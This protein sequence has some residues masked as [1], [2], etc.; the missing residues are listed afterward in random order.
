MPKSFSVINLGCAKNEVDGEG[1]RQVL[2]AAGHT[3]ALSPAHA[4]VVVVN[5][6]GFI[7]AATDESLAELRRLAASKRPG[8]M[9]VAAG[10]L[11]ERLGAQ[12]AQEVPQVDAVLGTLRWGEIARLLEAAA[13]SG[14]RPAWIG[15]GTPEPCVPRQAHGG[16]AYLKIADGCSAACAFCTIPAIKG[17]YRSRPEEDIV[18]EAAALAAQGVRELVLIAQDSTY[19]GRDRGERGALVRLL[20]R[21][22][23]V[24]P[25]VPWLRLMYAYPTHLD[26]D[27]LRLM[28]AEPRLVPYL[29]LPLQHAHPDVLRRMGRPARDPLQLVAELRQAVPG[30]TLRSTFI[31]GFPGESDA[32]FGALLRFLE[33]VRLERVGVFAYSAEDGTPAA[34]M[35]GQVPEE[36]KQRRLGEAMRLQQN[37]SL[38]LNREQIGRTLDVLVEG[39]GRLERGPSRGHQRRGQVLV[40]GRSR[41]D[42]PEVDGLVFFPGAAQPGDMVRVRVTQALPYDLVGRQLG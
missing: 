42:A 4:D 27:L 12:I 32:E 10:C 31:V 11:A 5:T 22:L 37:I 34:E 6:C 19:Y 17:P 2:L 29:D 41:R 9:L 16:S 14:E 26:G 38:A 21:L 3:A 20:E 25:A 8:Q 13:G 39:R 35:P 18:G 24:T 33:A 40:C 23:A 28:A 1:L 7:Q 30:L 36:A 15:V